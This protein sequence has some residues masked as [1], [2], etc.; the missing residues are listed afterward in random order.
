[1]EYTDVAA[2]ALILGA[3]VVGGLLAMIHAP[4]EDNDG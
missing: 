3:A 4:K 1:V 2:W